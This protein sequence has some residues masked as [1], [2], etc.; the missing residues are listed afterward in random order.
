MVCPAAPGAARSLRVPVRLLRPRARAAGRAHAET[1]WP[2]VPGGPAAAASRNGAAA[3]CAHGMRSIS[4]VVC[5]AGFVNGP[6]RAAPRR[7]RPP[8]RRCRRCRPSPPLPPVRAPPRRCRPSVPHPD[9]PQHCHPRI[10]STH[11]CRRCR[12]SAPLP[13]VRRSTPALTFHPRAAARPPS[14]SVHAP[15]LRERAAPPGWH[16][17]HTHAVAVIRPRRASVYRRGMAQDGTVPPRLSIPARRHSRSTLCFCALANYHGAV[18]TNARP[19]CYAEASAGRGR[20]APPAALPRETNRGRTLLQPPLPCR[21]KRTGTGRPRNPRARRAPLTARRAGRER[22]AALPRE[23]NRTRTL[24]PPAALPRKTNRGRTSPQPPR[25]PRPAH[26]A[27]RRKGTA[28]CPAAENEPGA[29]APANPAPAAPCSPRGAPEGNGPPPCRGNGPGRGRPANP[30]PAAP[31]S[32]RGA[33]EGNGPP[34]CRRGRTGGGRSCNPRRP[35]GE[36]DRGVDVP[37]NPAPAAPRPPRGA[38]E[39]NGSPPKT[40]GLRA[41]HRAA[42]GKEAACSASSCP[43]CARWRR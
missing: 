31:C 35:A 21:G 17:R 1:G 39:G 14:H 15:P 6:A 33:P 29:D 24:R 2:R 16:P 23:T 5:R 18:L 8:V 12:P 20:S 43:R 36:T 3:V 40:N 10:P 26:R 34:P 25:P 4:I 41:R 27:A 13:P 32:P 19:P 9:A 22:P 30:A 37:A 42:G 38:P 7:C 28:R 11:R